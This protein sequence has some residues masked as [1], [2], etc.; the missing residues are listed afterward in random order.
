MGL[1]QDIAKEMLRLYPNKC[2]IVR[3]KM[4]HGDAVR[5][6]VAKIEEAHKKAGE[7]RLHFP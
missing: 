7:S 6:Y 3:I 4:L 1:G 2:K 5:A